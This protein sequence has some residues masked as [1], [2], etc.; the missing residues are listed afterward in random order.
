MS[1]ST[2]C[3]IPFWFIKTIGRRHQKFLRNTK[4][5]DSCLSRYQP[6]MQCTYSPHAKAKEGLIITCYQLICIDKCRD[7]TQETQRMT[8]LFINGPKAAENPL[9]HAS[10][11]TP[12]A[13][14][15]HSAPYHTGSCTSAGV[16]NQC[17]TIKVMW[18]RAKER[19][20]ECK[21]AN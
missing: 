2:A 20:C 11:L 18:G 3:A 7:P 13:C 10:A 8:L 16:I 17:F 5:H 19:E 14:L 6:H 9:Q 4:K 15:K 21:G 1:G 12:R